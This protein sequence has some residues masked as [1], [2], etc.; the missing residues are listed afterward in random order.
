MALLFCKVYYNSVPR[1][2][3]MARR[4]KPRKSSSLKIDFLTERLVRMPARSAV[5]AADKRSLGRG[6][7]LI[8]E[9]SAYKPSTAAG[10]MGIS[11]QK[12]S[13]LR[14]QISSGEASSSVL[15]NLLEQTL[16]ELRQASE[17]PTMMHGKYTSEE[18]IDGRRVFD[19]DYVQAGTNFADKKMQWATP[20]KAGGFASLDSAL[21]WYG[22]ITGGAE[23]FW[24][25]FD[26]NGRWFVYDVRTASERSKSRKG[27][28][29]GKTKAAKI[30]DEYGQEG[31]ARK[32]GK[33]TRRKRAKPAKKKSGGRKSKGKSNAGR[34]R[35]RSR[36]SVASGKRRKASRS[37]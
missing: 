30:F 36:R 28:V 14:K 12:Y 1:K 6:R 13:S 11:T 8:D 10:V 24:I 18:A 37:R 9:L 4:Q 5:N 7:D 21:N 26:E 29:T 27:K 32:A 2:N 33:T 17:L 15:N 25:M 22:A 3:V 31:P 34:K 20:A 23:Y 19:I 16:D 35:R